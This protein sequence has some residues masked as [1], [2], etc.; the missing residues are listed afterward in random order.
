MNPYALDVLA[1]PPKDVAI[2]EWP[3]TAL[4]RGNPLRRGAGSNPVRGTFTVGMR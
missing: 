2:Q 4:R 3:D 1:G